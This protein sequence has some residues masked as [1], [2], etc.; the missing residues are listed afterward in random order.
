MK[1]FKKK[2][3]KETWKFSAHKDAVAVVGVFFQVDEKSLD[4]V[5]RLGSTLSF[6]DI[7]Q[8][9]A[10]FGGEPNHYKGIL[11]ELPDDLPE[12][13]T[14]EISAAVTKGAAKNVF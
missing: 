9:T 7:L 13:R 11:I 14:F 1:W 12:A 8:A 3:K 2:K 4:E 6:A 10:T 5:R